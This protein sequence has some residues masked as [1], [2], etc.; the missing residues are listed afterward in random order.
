[1]MKRSILSGLMGVCLFVS[2]GATAQP[3]VQAGFS[4]E[5][6]AKTGTVPTE[7]AETIE[8]SFLT[9]SIAPTALSF[10]L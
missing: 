5:G 4:P 9:G 2:V 8:L 6:W 3:T 7:F 1:M 10:I